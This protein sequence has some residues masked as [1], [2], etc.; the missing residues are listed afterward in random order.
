M[1]EDERVVAQANA[2]VEGA[3]RTTALLGP[4]LAGVL[5]AT[6]GATNVLY[7]DACTFLVRGAHDRAVRAAPAAAAA[8]P[9]G[10]GR[11]SPA[12]ASSR[13]TRCCGRSAITALFLNMF[14]QMLAASLPVLAYEQ[15]GGSSRVAGPSSRPSA[16]A[17]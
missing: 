11:A 8:D 16:R 14:G 12:C 15:F 13:A 5:I 4:A 6:I 2:I 1:G 3:Q 9:G 10:E 7:I 17:R